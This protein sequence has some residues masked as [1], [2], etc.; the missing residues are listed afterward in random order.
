MKCLFHLSL[1]LSALAI[2][3]GRPPAPPAPP[4]TIHAVAVLPPN[5]RTDDPL[6]FKNDLFWDPFARRSKPVTVADCLAAEARAQLEQRGFSVSSPEEVEKAIGSR[7]PEN[8][9]EAA[10]LATQGK[11]SGSVLYLEIKRWE[12]DMPIRPARVLVAMEASLIDTATGQVVWTGHQALQP[13]PT[14]GA[15]NLWSA[16]MIVAHNVVASLLSP[17]G[18]EQPSS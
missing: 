2:S 16:Y 6:L 11:L 18:P 14:P 12:P 13:M 17:W 3:C 5:N 7:P 10:A 15:I 1:L 4:A 8:P 9:Q